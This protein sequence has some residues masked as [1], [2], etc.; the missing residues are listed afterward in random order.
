MNSLL[1]KFYSGGK[2]GIVEYDSYFGGIFTSNYNQQQHKLEDATI[3]NRSTQTMNKETAQEVKDNSTK[4]KVYE[5]PPIDLS[6]EAIYPLFD[7]TIIKASSPLPKKEE[8]LEEV[9]KKDI[10][11]QLLEEKIKHIEEKHNE[12]KNRLLDII[13]KQVTNPIP[14]L[15]DDNETMNTTMNSKKMK[16]REVIANDNTIQLIKQLQ[17]D[18]TNKIEEGNKKNRNNMYELNHN[19]KE[20][21]LAVF[22]KIDDMDRQQRLD[23]EKVKYILD[24]SGSSR[25]QNL[26]KRLLLERKKENDDI[27]F[28]KNQRR[29][30]S[31]KKRGSSSSH[32]HKRDDRHKESY[33]H[34]RESV[35]SPKGRNSSESERGS[36]HSKSRIKRIKYESSNNK[37]DDEIKEDQSVNS[38]I[39]NKKRLLQSVNFINSKTKQEKEGKEK[40]NKN[41][42]KKSKTKYVSEFV[43]EEET[44]LNSPKSTWVKGIKVNADDKDKS[45][46]NSLIKGVKPNDDKDKSPRNSLI[47]GLKPNNEENEKSGRDSLKPI[48][49]DSNETLS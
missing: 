3:I 22:M 5:I 35:R 36:I 27:D 18:I 21:K 29:H 45:P 15:N 12:E 17:K 43:D 28:T 19:F 41:A 16:V 23:L 49:E 2:E 4:V 10:A 31:S 42:I 38:S 6:N 11:V 48:K 8:K 40:E 47:K 33:K 30:S 46:R 24:H 7:T 39:S 1:K 34:T 44:K 14:T 25:V 13:N 9:K 37:E 20:L 26:S 32:H